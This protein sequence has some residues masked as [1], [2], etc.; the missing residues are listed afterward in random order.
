M[1][2]YKYVLQDNLTY[3]VVE[4]QTGLV[5]VKG[6]SQEKARDTTKHLNF[7]GGFAGWTPQFILKEFKPLDYID[8]KVYQYQ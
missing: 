7:G 6:V 8:N 3:N 2:D 5:V 1:M 4:N